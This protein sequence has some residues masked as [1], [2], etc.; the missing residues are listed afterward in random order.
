MR[1]NCNWNVFI[2]QRQRH[3]FESGGGQI[4]RA[5]LAEIFFDPTLFGQWGDKILLR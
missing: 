4:L 5:K 1:P 2:D 3:G